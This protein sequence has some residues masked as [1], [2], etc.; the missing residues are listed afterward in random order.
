MIVVFGI[1]IH[2]N[3]GNAYKQDTRFQFNSGLWCIFTKRRLMFWVYKGC[4]A[5]FLQFA[6]KQ[7]SSHYIKYIIFAPTFNVLFHLFRLFEILVKLDLEFRLHLVRHTETRVIQLKKY[8]DLMNVSK[9]APNI[10][11]FLRNLIK[12]SLY[13]LFTNVG[14]WHQIGA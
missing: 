8:N 10:K 7:A 5:Y 4:Q 11:N 12:Y 14:V 13:A 9:F 1:F 3:Q 6:R 2:S